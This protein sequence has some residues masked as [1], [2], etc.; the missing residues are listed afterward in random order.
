MIPV[1]ETAAAPDHGVAQYNSQKSMLRLASILVSAAFMLY[2]GLWG[3]LALDPYVRQLSGE[4]RWLE[5]LLMGLALQTLSTLVAFPVHFFTEF[6]VEHRF[7]LSTQSFGRFMLKWLKLSA[8]A[9]AFVPPLLSSIYWLLWNFPNWW[10]AVAATLMFILNGLMGMLVP[11]I[12]APLFYK[13]KPLTDPELLE[14]FRRIGASAGI[15]ITAV[16]TADVSAETVKVNACMIGLGKT[17]RVILAD[18]L[19]GKF[20]PEELDV[21]FA[22]EVGHYAHRHLLKLLVCNAVVMLLG[23]LV[24]AY[25]LNAVAVPLG[26]ASFSAPSTLALFA[27]GLSAFSAVIVPIQNILVRHFEYQADWFALDRTENVPAFRSAFYR[28]IES[29][30]AE[31]S[32]PRWKVWLFDNH[33]STDDRLGRASDWL[34]ARGANTD[35]SLGWLAH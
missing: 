31:L 25:V 6:V 18:T 13:M 10:W 20:T 23:F 12:V 4:N 30:K 5:V 7:G 35:H 15:E 19:L 27:L 21:I 32:R 11:V 1:T 28:L 9:L 24:G 29:N 3:G 26:H 16:F 2:M 17:K 14:R 33:P 34:A 8:L 22:H